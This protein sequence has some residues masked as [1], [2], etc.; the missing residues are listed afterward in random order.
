MTK[1]L[2]LLASVGLLFAVVFSAL[3]FGAVEA[4]ATALL[5]LIIAGVAALWVART[6][7]AGRI[8]LGLPAVALPIALLTV[9]AAIQGINISST[10]GA[11]S[12]ISWDPDASR[13]AAS[14]MVFMLV[15]F[16]LASTFFASRQRIET[17][18]RFLIIYG[19]VLALFALIQ[20][21]TWN[22]AFYWVRPT[23]THGFGP[24]ANRDHFAGYME[25]MAPLPIALLIAGV[26]PRDLRLLLGF[27]GAIMGTAI[28]ASL[29]RGGILSFV[30]GT[31][32]T[33]VASG[34]R[35]ESR[36]RRILKFAVAGGILAS[37]VVGTLWIGAAPIVN[38]AA[39]TLKEASGAQPNYY[40]R[41][42]L[43][44]DT[45]ALIRSTPLTGSGAGAFETSFPAFSH[46]SGQYIVAQSHNDYLQ[47]L[48]D[49]G[50]VGGLLG[51]IF[52]LLLYF[53]FRKALAAGD[54][55]LS[56][57]ALGCSGGIFA[58]LVH[59][60]FDFNLQIPSNA[61]MFLF[62]IAIVCSIGRV[63][64]VAGNS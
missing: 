14:T 50:V 57:V 43:W 41:R 1:R 26:A 22:G 52:L 46:A 29:S 24:F 36:G 62:L 33:V 28:V 17:A 63:G 32:F 25:M 31:L 20:S 47:L 6:I 13:N 48:A 44:S 56:A 19:A 9:W 7:A 58:L 23:I 55:F 49:C 40:S 34:L 61:L 51:V 45:W 39:E 2:D 59:S 15:F 12:S 60:L 54:P 53:A 35:R 16:L 8:E 64:S 11:P 3:A 30:M 27:A 21:L 10:N 5:E 4:W 37:V 18:A 38:R 42:W